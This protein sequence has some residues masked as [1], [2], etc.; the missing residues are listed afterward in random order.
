MSIF[1][2]KIVFVAILLLCMGLFIAVATKNILKIFLGVIITYNSSI[3]L[4]SC[5]YEISDKIL[6]FVLS[7]LT[8]FIFFAGFFTVAKV[9]KKYN[10]L[11]LSKIEEIAKGEK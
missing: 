9:Y 3:L 11:D 1:T 4:L 5:V 7:A 10:T 2:L 6:A 8:P